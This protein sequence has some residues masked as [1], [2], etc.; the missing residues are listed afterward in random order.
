MEGLYEYA[1]KNVGKEAIGFA[2][3]IEHELLTDMAKNEWNNRM[4]VT[5]YPAEE[6]EDVYARCAQEFAAS[7]D[8]PIPDEQACRDL[9]KS[10]TERGY[11]LVRVTALGSISLSNVA[12][13]FKSS[14]ERLHPRSCYCNMSPTKIVTFYS[15]DKIRTVD[16]LGR[17]PI[18]D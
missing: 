13:N 2:T 16:L 18:K 11:P 9:A 8:R 12:N 5:T 7:K 10:Y 15:S 3:A 4:E 14:C 1:I 17:L 6:A